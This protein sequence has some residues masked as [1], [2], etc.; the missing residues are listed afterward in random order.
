MSISILVEPSETGFRATTGAPLDL[1]ADAPSAAEA[2]NALNEKIARRL[3]TGAMLVEH[4]GPAPR[5]P[6]AILPLADNPLVD[7]WL[8]AVEELRSAPPPGSAG[9]ASELPSSC[10]TPICSAFISAI[11]P[12]FWLPLRLGRPT[13]SV[14]AR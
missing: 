9:D 4:P 11:K 1:S 14:S 6:I 2:V 13:N 3:Q 10:S 7:D 8:A 5:P 12:K